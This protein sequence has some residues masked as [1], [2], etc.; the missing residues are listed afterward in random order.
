MSHGCR[1]ATTGPHIDNIVR[2]DGWKA[3]PP[4]TPSRSP[5]RG[6]DGVQATVLAEA[7]G[8]LRRQSPQAVAVPGA[9]ATKGPRTSPSPEKLS[10]FLRPAIAVVAVL[11]VLGL[12]VIPMLGTNLAPRPLRPSGPSL[13]TF[14]MPRI[15]VPGPPPTPRV[16][17]SPASTGE[18]GAEARSG[19]GQ[20]GGHGAVA[21]QV[22]HLT[23]DRWAVQAQVG[24]PPEEGSQRDD[25]LQSGQAG[26]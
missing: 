19:S 8:V 21:A 2:C 5:H 18:G 6:V 12:V 20:R 26:S 9:P 16:R 25:A 17:L 7:R 15:S 4:T 23:R 3:S 24:I 11:V 1:S 13:P 14:S 22:H 10:Y